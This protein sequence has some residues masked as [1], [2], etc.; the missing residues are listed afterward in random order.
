MVLDA[1]SPVK[2]SYYHLHMIDILTIIFSLK[3]DGIG[4]S[5]FLRIDK[6]FVIDSTT[7]RNRANFIN[8]SCDVSI[9]CD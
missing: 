5:Y 4:S 9:L 6:D 2:T 3:A 8:Y 7:K 1:N